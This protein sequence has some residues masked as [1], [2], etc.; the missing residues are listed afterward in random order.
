[1]AKL[2]IESARS[3]A[4]ELKTV[5]SVYALFVH[6]STAYNEARKSTNLGRIKLVNGKSMIGYE[7]YATPPIADDVDMFCIENFD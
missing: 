1:L 2:N 7:F 3:V 4:T 5:P 6:G